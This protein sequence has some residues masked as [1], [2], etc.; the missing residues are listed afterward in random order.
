MQTKVDMSGIPKLV[1]EYNI[2]Y[3]NYIYYRC[4]QQSTFLKQ[5]S[6]SNSSINHRFPSFPSHQTLKYISSEELKTYALE[7]YLD[8]THFLI[9]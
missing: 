8:I 5:P 4:I 9:S 6:W 1:Q 7:H 3:S 2:K